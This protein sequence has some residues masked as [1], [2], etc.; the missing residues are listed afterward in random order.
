MIMVSALL[1]RTG[2]HV[3][4]P[5][6]VDEGG[7]HALQVTARGSQTHAVGGLSPVLTARLAAR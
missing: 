3:A 5:V 6:A 7:E 4:G 2:A 1:T